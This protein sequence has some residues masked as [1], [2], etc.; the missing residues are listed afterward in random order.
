MTTEQEA[1]EVLDRSLATVAEDLG[2]MTGLNERAY[3]DAC[4][5]LRFLAA[6]WKGRELVPRRA[7]AMVL[8]M[9]NIMVNVSDRYGTEE[10]PIIVDKAAKLDEL[11]TACFVD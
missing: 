9:V 7:V 2:A 3:E 5:A 8:G 11:I 1:L 10:G 6:Q 4:V